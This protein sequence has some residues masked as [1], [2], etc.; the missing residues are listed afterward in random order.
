MPDQTEADLRAV[1]EESLRL[2][3][4]CLMPTRPDCVLALLDTITDLRAER[5]QIEAGVISR[6]RDRHAIWARAEA[7]EADATALRAGIE[8]LRDEWRRDDAREL[9]AFG[10]HL[11]GGAVLSCSEHLTALLDPKN[12]ANTDE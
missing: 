8:A 12:G 4:G 5:D 9:D 2:A 10:Q 11:M 1:A 6:Y 3:P 7:A